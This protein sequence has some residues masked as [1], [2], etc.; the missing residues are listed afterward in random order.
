MSG[1]APHHSNVCL[2]S[3]RGKILH[4]LAVVLIVLMVPIGAGCSSGNGRSASAM[5][6]TYVSEA[7]KFRAQLQGP[8]G[9]ASFL[10]L[11][12]APN[13]LAL[14]FEK[15]D[16]VAPPDIEPDVA[17]IRDAFKAEANGAGAAALN[18][19]GALVSGL[20]QGAATS[21]SF[22]RVDSW[23]SAHCQAQLAQLQGTANGASTPANTN[24][25]CTVLE[26]RP[27][28]PDQTSSDS[29]TAQDAPISD[30]T[31]VLEKLATKG[32]TPLGDAVTALRVAINALSPP[33]T[34]TLEALG[35]IRFAGQ[36]PAAL[37]HRLD[38]A[39]EQACGADV[40]GSGRADFLNTLGPSPIDD[41]SAKL[42]STLFGAPCKGPDVLPPFGV[43]YLC[44]RTK[45]NVIG[46]NE[47]NDYKI[48]D[49]RTGSMRVI[50]DI[51]L[52]E[53]VLSTGLAAWEET[54]TTPA[55]GLSVPLY[56]TTL[57]IQPFDG[58]PKVSVPIETNS[59]NPPAAN[60]GNPNQ[61]GIF[62]VRR[63]RVLVADNNK[64]FLFDGSGKQIASPDIGTYV[65]D[66][67]EKAIGSDGLLLTGGD[68]DAVIFDFNSGRIIDLGR[69]EY[70]AD[71]TQSGCNDR[72]IVH[73]TG[74]VAQDSK[75]WLVTDT[76]SGLAIAAV[77][78]ST[79]DGGLYAARPNVLVTNADGNQGQQFGAEGLHLNGTVAWSLGADVIG[80]PNV[81]GG[82]VV[83]HNQS[84]QM[85]IIDPE[86]GKLATDLSARLNSLLLNQNIDYPG[87]N[88]NFSAF[89][90]DL[91]QDVTGDPT[92]AA[93]LLFDNQ[94][95]I[96]TTIPS[97]ELCPTG[98]SR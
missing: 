33:A 81:I 61:G 54:T 98:N 97:A 52:L 55:Q 17:T 37:V 84:G 7:V 53:S 63:D 95:G 24:P 86:T 58:R 1:L 89:E 5:C 64:Y 40:F 82:W 51:P 18:P 45:S 39:T 36:D 48:V 29:S 87:N 71:L 80:I 91:G 2:H 8:V 46:Q 23:L 43:G 67:G 31:G 25:D 69:A 20:A 32:G 74:I 76:S 88:G 6:D 93:V 78:P 4:R 49:L 35:R 11:L 47:L 77:Q 50:P 92:D 10:S 27:V 13:D 72:A 68:N 85:L 65:V 30:L 90:S 41:A 66:Q 83:G 60:S 12:S 62:A 22:T 3:T 28:S 73:V 44:R 70:G 56:S 79:Q 9:L 57:Y 75:T 19:V 14:V 34:T 42:T 96:V 15:M 26:N 94:T 21:G 59:V 38:A 16:R